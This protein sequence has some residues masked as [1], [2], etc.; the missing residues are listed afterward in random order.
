MDAVA[1]QSQLLVDGVGV[2]W[3]RAVQFALFAAVAG[4]REEAG[5]SGARVFLVPEFLGQRVECHLRI[6][7]RQR[8]DYFWRDRAAFYL[9]PE[10]RAAAAQKARGSNGA[11]R[12][13]AE[14]QLHLTICDSEDQARHW[15]I[16]R[17]RF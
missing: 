4:L 12:P 3:E 2:C 6:S 17:W 5:I 1:L 16:S 7:H 14:L 15:Y 8:A 10:H 11:A 9:R 13:S